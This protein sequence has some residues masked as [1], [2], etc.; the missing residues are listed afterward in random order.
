[1]RYIKFGGPH[2][3]DA[4][5]QAIEACEKGEVARALRRLQ[6]CFQESSFFSAPSATLF[7]F[8]RPATESARPST[9]ESAKGRLSDRRQEQT[10][11]LRTLHVEILPFG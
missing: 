5:T 3:G 1:M 7:E 10:K 11:A 6:A 8:Q 2:A 4:A 9:D